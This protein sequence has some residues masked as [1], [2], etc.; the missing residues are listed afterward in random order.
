[1]A[2]NLPKLYPVKRNGGLY[3]YEWH[4]LEKES[5]IWIHFAIRISAQ[6]AHVF[7]FQRVNYFSNASKF[8]LSWA[9]VLIKYTFIS[10]HSRLVTICSNNLA[11]LPEINRGCTMDR[12]H[13]E[14]TSSNLCSLRKERTC[15]RIIWH[16]AMLA[17]YRWD[18]RDWCAE[19]WHH[20]GTHR[21]QHVEFCRASGCASNI[22]QHHQTSSNIIKHHPTS[23]NT[24]Q[25]SNNLPVKTTG[26][27]ISNS[28]VSC[29]YK[30]S[31]F[32]Y[33]E[34][35]WVPLNPEP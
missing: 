20:P 31:G 26:P 30:L 6:L 19:G 34:K 15:P 10:D 2:P 7:L 3:K 16:H 23:S 17:R 13:V 25:P 5:L 4:I 22:I 18:W 14:K 28:N 8:G 11:S 1:M 24:I 21:R 12:K 9:G 32:I 29:G 35:R 33:P 27:K